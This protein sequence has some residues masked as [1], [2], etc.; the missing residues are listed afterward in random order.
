MKI[1]PHIQKK[2]R[3]LLLLGAV[4]LGTIIVSQYPTS[5]AK[6]TKSVGISGV[7]YT[8]LEFSYHVQDPENKDNRGGGEIVNAF[9]A[10]GIRCCYELP[11]VWRPGMKLKIGVTQPNR[12]K[13][14]KNQYEENH[15]EHIV[16]VPQYAQGLPGDLWVIRNA[17]E[18]MSVVLSSVQPD[19]EQWPGKVKGWPVPS[20]A[21]QR[22]IHDMYVREA[23][24]GVRLYESLLAKL[25]ADPSKRAKE[26][27][28]FSEQI[29]KENYPDP[30]KP[31]SR[32]FSGE[33]GK[34]N[35]DLLRR[36]KGPDDP[37]FRAWLKA[38]Y[39]EKLVQEKEK[40]A[41]VLRERP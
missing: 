28:E 11:P 38:D 26:S 30:S 25:K 40:L 31:P 21:Y 13:L 23:E 20:L 3:L 22:K 37:A 5:P 8:D 1:I 34:A 32:S 24:H 19:H 41:Q 12:E 18:T 10:G 15:E 36:F 2:K 6:T 9:A 16:E 17:D 4:L 27:W 39:E 29:V 7:N 33:I 35:Y 14:E